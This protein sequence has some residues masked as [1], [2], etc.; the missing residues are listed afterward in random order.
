MTEYT[1]RL[2]ERNNQNNHPVKL[3]ALVEFVVVLF[4][5]CPG[6]T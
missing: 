3:A 6:N 4:Q 2:G 1:G 5:S